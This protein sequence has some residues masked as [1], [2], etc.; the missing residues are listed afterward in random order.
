[1][2][3]SWC[4]C[5]CLGLPFLSGVL[6][7]PMLASPSHLRISFL[8]QTTQ[9]PWKKDL[10]T[11]DPPVSPLKP[12]FMVL[13]SAGCLVCY[14]LYLSFFYL[15]M[16]C[17]P[18]WSILSLPELTATVHLEQGLTCWLSQLRPGK[19]VPACLSRVQWKGRDKMAEAFSPSLEQFSL[20]GVN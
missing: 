14:Y 12:Q 19:E 6:K 10:R 9:S 4:L 18:H 5:S 20:F 1:M 2:R 11:F 3:L 17:W 13:F 15:E 7:Q 8:A 16:V